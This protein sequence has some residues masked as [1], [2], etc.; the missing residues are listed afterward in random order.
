MRRT[1]TRF[2]Q[3]IPPEVR[4]CSWRGCTDR[5]I[6]GSRFCAVHDRAAQYHGRAVTA[7]CVKVSPWD[8]VT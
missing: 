8:N 4:S 7:A 1:N 2:G 5:C 3:G 6:T